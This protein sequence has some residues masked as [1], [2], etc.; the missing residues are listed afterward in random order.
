MDKIKILV[1]QHK[2]AQV[3]SNEVY[4]PIHVGKA[5]SKIDL[6]IIGDDTGDNISRKNPNYCELT[7]Q[8]WMWKNMHDVEYVGLCNY[9][10]Y[11]KTQFTAENIDGIMG[12]CDVI[13]V[14]PIHQKY[15]LYEKIYRTLV[16]ENAAIFF[17]VIEKYF[18][19]YK[20]TVVNYMMNNNK[21]YAYNMFVCRKTVFDDFAKWQFSVLAECEKHI[22][23]TGFV[24]TDRVFGYI[25]EYLLPIYFLHNNKKIKTMEITGMLPDNG[26]KALCQSKAGAIRN[27]VLYHL[28]HI[29]KKK[30]FE[31]SASV[32]ISLQQCLQSM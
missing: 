5:L 15:A 9:R 21:D 24:S 4:T 29:R 20:E 22:K 3:F 6:G 30:D 28:G 25:S 1:A 27:D 8:Y 13:L 11:F 17:R 23:L 16:E 18:P 7:A 2:A 12:N 10:R 14:K 31:I 32:K 19:D 26:N